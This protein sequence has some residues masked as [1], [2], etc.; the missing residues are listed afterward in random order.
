MTS[1]SV[2]RKTASAAICVMVR[3]AA[4]SHSA[5]EVITG[6]ES[7]TGRLSWT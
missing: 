3:V 1:K 4:V 7:G 6:E 2:F 5:A